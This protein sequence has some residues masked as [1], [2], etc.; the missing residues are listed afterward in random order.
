VNACRPLSREGFEGL[1]AIEKAKGVYG[2]LEM[3]GEVH[4]LAAAL[5]DAGTVVV[6]SGEGWDAE[7]AQVRAAVQEKRK[8]GATVVHKVAEIGDVE[9]LKLIHDDLRVPLEVMDARGGVPLLEAAA[10]GKLECV[11]FYVF[12]K[13]VDVNICDERG[14]TPLHLAAGYGHLEVVK[15]LVEHDA[16]IDALTRLKVTPLLYAT[17]KGRIDVVKYL[18]RCGAN[19]DAQ[20]LEKQWN[21]IHTAVGCNQENLVIYFAVKFP[22]RFQ[23]LR[24]LQSIAAVENCTA[25]YVAL[26]KLKPKISQELKRLRREREQAERTEKQ[27]EA[28]LLAQRDYRN[29][30]RELEEDERIEKRASENKSSSG[31]EA[32][33]KK[34]KKHRNIKKTNKAKQEQSGIYTN[35]ASNKDENEP[36][37]DKDKGFEKAE[38]PV[39]IATMTVE[40]E[41]FEDYNGD[42][43]VKLSKREKRRRRENAS[44]SSETSSGSG[45]QRFERNRD[46]ISRS[47]TPLRGVTSV[48][49]SGV[50]PPRR[51]TSGETRWAL[52]KKST[53]E[54]GSTTE[55]TRSMTLDTAES[56]TESTNTTKEL[57]EDSAKPSNDMERKTSRLRPHAPPWSPRRQKWT[58]PAANAGQVKTKVLVET[59]A[60]VVENEFQRM[61]KRFVHMDTGARRTAKRKFAKATKEYEEKRLADAEQM[62]NA[63]RSSVRRRLQHGIENYKYRQMQAALSE[64][65]EAEEA[66]RMDAENQHTILSQDETLAELAKEASELLKHKARASLSEYS[67]PWGGG[68]LIVASA[69][70]DTA[71]QHDSNLRERGPI[72]CEALQ[73]RF[74]IDLKQSVQSWLLRPQT[75]S[76]KT[77]IRFD[78]KT[79]FLIPA[80]VKVG[81]NFEKAHEDFL[82]M[83]AEE[84]KLH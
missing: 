36:T 25:S 29:L 61:L 1:G 78:L 83:V 76:S 69:F 22:G 44:D 77:Y 50:T 74:E 53:M 43:Q 20:D 59:P 63:W 18:L 82:L 12:D 49:R 71:F 16:E 8:D 80:A 62:E 81:F 40:Q 57:Q 58:S 51:K 19:V 4:R 35:Q 54:N 45:K 7:P 3:R 56:E 34:K 27:R 48:A 32:S 75:E 67:K 11:K 55:E 41:D 2:V 5:E 28:N 84:R 33:K 65:E 39:T 23:D 9:V 79:S 47:S 6:W 72:E 24:Y 15:W 60:E 21:A 66:R 10:A 17:A 52:G 68:R 37:P 73:R 13:G 14:D 31:N 26:N 30:L 42:W 38:Q 70:F 46:P 64:I